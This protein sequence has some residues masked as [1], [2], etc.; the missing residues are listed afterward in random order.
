MSCAR[1]GAHSLA[2]ELILT[3]NLCESQSRTFAHTER[4]REGET[5]I[6]V[7]ANEILLHVRHTQTHRMYIVH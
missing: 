3:A 6:D 5:F 1:A 2:M 4:E 7:T